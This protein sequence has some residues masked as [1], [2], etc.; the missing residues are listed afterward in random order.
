MSLD[1]VHG[2]YVHC[3]EFGWL[4]GLTGLGLACLLKNGVLRVE[5]TVLLHLLVYC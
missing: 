4:L 5:R 2:R 3:M 1:G